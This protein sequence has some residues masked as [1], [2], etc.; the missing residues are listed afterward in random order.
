MALQD[1]YR[2][3][4]ASHQRHPRNVGEL[5][6]GARAA[7]DNPSC[8][9]QVC[10]SLRLDEG[11]TLSLRFTGRGCA[12]SQASASMLTVA[13]QGKTP[14]QARELAAQFRAMV[15][16]EAPPSPALGDLTALQGVSRLHAR[17]KCALLAWQAL[18]DALNAVSQPA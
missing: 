4:I 16:G 3:L 14:A 1:L 7:R 18:E 13:L 15:M 5:A 6:G 8:G 17:R 11:D 2:D 12:V 9:D 10:L